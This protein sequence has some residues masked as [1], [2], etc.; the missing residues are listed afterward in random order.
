MHFGFP[1]DLSEVDLSDIDILDADLYLLDAD[2]YGKHFVCL[3][4]VFKTCLQE[5]SSRRHPYIF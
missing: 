4:G 5:I 2:V 3:Q 1:L